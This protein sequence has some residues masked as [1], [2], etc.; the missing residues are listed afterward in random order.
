MIVLFTG[1]LG[2]S[3][4]VTGD[5]QRIRPGEDKGLLQVEV[6][7]SGKIIRGRHPI[8]QLIEQAEDQATKLQELKDSVKTLDDAV[9]NYKSTFGLD[10]PEGFDKWYAT[11]RVERIPSH[12]LMG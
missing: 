10:P 8:T 9:A 7:V 11:F 5:E 4:S 6:P 1:F 2:L 12:Q 3:Y